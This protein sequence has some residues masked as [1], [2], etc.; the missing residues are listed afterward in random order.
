MCVC[1]GVQVQTSY[2]C[3]FPSYHHSVVELNV[4][5]HCNVE[6]GNFGTLMNTYSVNM[7]IGDQR[8]CVGD[9]G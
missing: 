3:M 1:F 5:H 8:Q 7:Y 4:S 2:G 9:C 6:N